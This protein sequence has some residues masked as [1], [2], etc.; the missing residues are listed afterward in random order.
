MYYPHGAT[1]SNAT[2]ELL[3]VPTYL[4]HTPFFGP[5]NNIVF[6]VDRMPA[7]ERYLKLR[8]R[9]LGRV[10]KTTKAKLAGKNISL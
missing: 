8:Y 1:D 6:E 3:L 9:L 5:K 10:R 4:L 2:P 7:L